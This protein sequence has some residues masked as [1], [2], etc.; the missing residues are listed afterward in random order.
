[1]TTSP[2]HDPQNDRA[3][4]AAPEPP[5]GNPMTILLLLLSPLVLVLLWELFVNH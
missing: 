5:A 1:M 2:I 3:E 4:P